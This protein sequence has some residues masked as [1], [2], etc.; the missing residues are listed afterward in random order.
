M[1]VAVI[2]QGYVGLPLAMQ[3]VAVGHEV[4]ALE[5]AA[6]RVN[7]LQRGE[8][9][10]TD[11]SSAQLQDA[12][13]T[14]RYAVSD[15]PD[16]IRGFDI[17]IITVPTPLKDGAPDLSCVENASVTVGQYLRPGA[18]VVLE[19]TS[20]PGTTEQ[21]V[22]PRLEKWSQLSTFDFHVGFSPERI[23]P[24]NEQWRFRNTPKL[25]S[26]LQPC[27][28]DAVDGFYRTIVD[29]TVR[30][31]SLVVAELAK[32]V[33]NTFRHVNIGLVNELATVAQALG[34]SVWEV[35]D[36]ADTKPYG[37]MKFTPGP[38]V[39]G[40]CLPVDPA[41]L[42]WQVERDLGRRMQFIELA[43]DV[44][45]HMPHHV[46][47]RATTML[48]TACRSVNGSRILVLGLAYKAGTADVRESPSFKVI[49]LLTRGGAEVSLFDPWVE[50]AR[51]PAP[52]W[53]RL[54]P[55]REFDLVMLLTD[56]AEFTDELVGK[57]TRVL[58]CRNHLTPASNVQYL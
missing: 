6:N 44:N 37:F 58:D 30:T 57:A 20:Y 35:L 12:L 5:V 2:G 36:A 17:A 56:H 43:N 48:N 22:L 16:V 25:V 55:I 47:E 11:I 49:D 52:A 3:A 19:S 18:T 28:L 23:D 27:C 7:A 13:A 15:D 14:G 50:P 32:V 33:E 39:G 31:G 26:G 4:A 40:H 24:G 1:K 38:G 29:T 45:S 53:N 51:Y 46:V 42:S 41:Y 8:S 54:V 21:V 9:F 34:I 10:T